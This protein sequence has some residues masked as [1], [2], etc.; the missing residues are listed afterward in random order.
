[1]PAFR[2]AHRLI[3]PLAAAVAL[4]AA[5]PAAAADAQDYSPAE[6]ALFMDNQLN[7]VKPPATLRYEYHRTGTLDPAFDDNVTMSLAALP[8]GACCKVTADFLTGER[9]LK[10]PDIDAESGNPVI[11]YFLERDIAEMQRLTKGQK[12]YFRK[13]I[14]MAVYQAATLKEVSL[15]YRG[16]SVAG[17]EITIAPYSDDPLKERFKGLEGKRYTFVLS[18]AVPGGVYAI[19]TSVAGKAG[20]A[21]PLLAEEM[22][23]DGAEGGAPAR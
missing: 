8:G 5:L 22:V 4:A 21:Q 9:K 2:S 23:A 7:K 10:L 15:P 3:A 13:R 14:R 11:L 16:G 18:D 6:R 12:N 19:R 17:R 20:D 1:M